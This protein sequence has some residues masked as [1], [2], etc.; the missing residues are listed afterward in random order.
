VKKF[1]SIAITLAIILITNGLATNFLHLKF[2]DLA[3][4]T[5]FVFVMIISYFSFTGGWVSDLRDF[6]LQAITQ[7]KMK[8]DKRDFQPSIAL[9]T[10]IGYTIVSLL[11]TLIFDRSAF[12][13]LK[14]VLTAIGL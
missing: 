12:I 5:G 6:E 10:S 14:K 8:T 4:V 9:Y 13:I 3:F 1:L 2:M 7:M 11:V